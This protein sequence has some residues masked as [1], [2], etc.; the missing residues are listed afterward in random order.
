MHG[1]TVSA[2]AALPGWRVIRAGF[3]TLA[4]MAL[5]LSLAGFAPTVLAQPA[6]PAV[7]AA[8]AKALPAARPASAA[9][10]IKASTGPAWSEL[11]APQQQALKPLAAQWTTISEAQKR[12][13]L[14]LSQ[15]YPKLPPA[16]QA[17]LHSRM[18]EWVA[19]SPQERSAARLNFA[20]T[21]QITPDDKKAKWEAYQ[22]LSDE[23]K[24][25]LAEKASPKPVGAA[26]AVKPVPPQK[27]A[28]VKGKA[29][30][31]D[32]PKAEAVSPLVNQNTLLPNQQQSAAPL[33]AAVHQN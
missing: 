7:K 24:R 11:T 28:N 2:P 10:A 9:R 4:M 30:L 32:R 5:G 16:E 27:L 31:K 17:K 22:S 13:W 19:L 25:R 26:T 12:K 18:S 15:N 23:E 29:D 1:A 8:D 21:K 3:Q 20:A 33:P 6:T 14:A